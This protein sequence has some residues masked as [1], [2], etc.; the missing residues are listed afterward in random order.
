M[1]DDIL[2]FYYLCKEFPYIICEIVLLG[3]L[4]VEDHN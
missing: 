4:K 3:L 1:A 2:Q